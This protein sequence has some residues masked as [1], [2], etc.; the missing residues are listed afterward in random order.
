M[1]R[2]DLNWTKK[3]IFWLILHPMRH[4]L[5]LCWMKDLIKIYICGT[6]HQYSI[7]VCEIKNFQIFL[8][9]FSI[10]EVAPFCN[11]LGP[12]SPKYNLIL[13]KLWPEVVSNKKNTVFEKSFKIMNSGS[14][15]MQLKLGPNLLPKKQKYC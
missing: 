8:Y 4:T 12:Y 11:F 9:W 1:L 2:N 10:H 13:L 15:G 14:N 5:R 3:S 6:F 7:F